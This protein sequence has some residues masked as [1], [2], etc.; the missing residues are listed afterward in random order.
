MFWPDFMQNSGKS[1]ILHGYLAETLS[2][3]LYPPIYAFVLPESRSEE[4][5]ALVR[6]TM[7]IFC[8]EGAR[9]NFGNLMLS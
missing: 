7:L 2:F 6:Y 8:E 9:R 1:C 3:L 5:I 4:V